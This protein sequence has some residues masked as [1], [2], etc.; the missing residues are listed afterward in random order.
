MSESNRVHECVRRHGVFSSAVEKLGI[1]SSSGD[2]RAIGETASRG[3]SLGVAGTPRATQDYLVDWHELSL[4]GAIDCSH[5]LAA[6]PP[7]SDGG[8]CKQPQQRLLVSAIRR[9]DNALQ[10]VW[11]HALHG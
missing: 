4:P 7:R 11:L 3:R 9:H 10:S 8:G 2:E 5:S 6:A 1:A